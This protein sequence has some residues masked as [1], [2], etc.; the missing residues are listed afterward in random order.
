VGEAAIR[1]ALAGLEPEHVRARELAGRE[2]DAVKA[3]R[4]LARRGFDPD[5]VAELVPALDAAP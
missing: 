3:A 4:L 2:P 5:L 1:T